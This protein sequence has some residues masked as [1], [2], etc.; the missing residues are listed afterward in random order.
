MHLNFPTKFD[1]FAEW[2][3]AKCNNMRFVECHLNVTPTSFFYLP[4]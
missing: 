1:C 3:L 4:N 2:R